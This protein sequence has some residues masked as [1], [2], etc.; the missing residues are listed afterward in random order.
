MVLTRSLVKIAVLVLATVSI[1]AFQPLSPKLL[2]RQSTVLRAE[3]LDVFSETDVDIKPLLTELDLVKKKKELLALASATSRGQVT[4]LT[5]RGKISKAIAVLEASNPESDAAY[6]PKMIGQWLLVY[7][8]GD[9]TRSSPFFWAFRKLLKGQK[10]P[11][12]E[13][14]NLSEAVFRVTD[15]IPLRQIGQARQTITGSTA[16]PAASGAE[17]SEGDAE[18][19][20]VVDVTP[21]AV[22]DTLVSQVEVIAG[23]EK[24]K[25]F[26]NFKSVMTTTAKM[27]AVGPKETDL[28]VEKTQVKD[29]SIGKVF[30]AFEEFEFPTSRIFTQVKDQYT[31]TVVM[32]TT[33]LDDD[34]R[35]I[36]NK[37]GHVYVFVR[38]DA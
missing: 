30:P 14:E 29:S 28:T 15:S 21:V 38:E 3:D 26:P 6:S 20:G 16:E 32:K 13:N 25:F 17:K 35:I 19:E 9:V 31:A 7:G 10:N 24:G 4:T 23:S 33:Y 36:R 22:A 11:L 12:D 34:M 2:R 8:S 18:S 1:Q 37:F 27:E 5:Q